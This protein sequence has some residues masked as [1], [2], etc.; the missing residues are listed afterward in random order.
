MFLFIKDVLKK[1]NESAENRPAEENEEK[2]GQEEFQKE[3]KV[4]ENTKKEQ[5]KKEKKD[6]REQKRN[7]IKG[8][9][10]NPSF[11]VFYL[12]FVGIFISR[13]LLL[14]SPNEYLLKANIQYS[15][16]ER[17][18]LITYEIEKLWND[19][20]LN[21]GDGVC[22]PPYYERSD[23]A[24][25]T[26]NSK[27]IKGTVIG[28]GGGGGGGGDLPK[29]MSVEELKTFTEKENLKDIK[30]KIYIRIKTYGNLKQIV[31]VKPRWLEN[32]VAF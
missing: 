9:I 20:N 18:Y 30:G 4:K 27:C 2:T 25:P 11:I 3:K 1:I 29:Y 5:K 23:S 8:K 31:E 32:L 21:V 28:G 10:L 19:Y 14:T 6:K 17:K 26:S 15:S 7:K 24:T 16:I 12:V 22:I 13:I